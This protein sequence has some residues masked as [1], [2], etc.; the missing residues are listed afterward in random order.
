MPLELVCTLCMSN[1]GFRARLQNRVSEESNFKR[2][3]HSIFLLIKHEFLRLKFN[4]AA[5]R[6]ILIIQE[7]LRL[8]FKM[9]A[10]RPI[11]IIQYYRLLRNHLRM[12]PVKFQIIISKQVISIDVTRICWLT[13]SLLTNINHYKWM[14]D[15]IFN[16]S[17]LHVYYSFGFF[18]YLLKLP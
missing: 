15:H 5:K 8:K 7:F 10:K 2:L 11:L 17:N 3:S 14:A 16:N 13:A 4:M 1:R 12:F 6:P 18:K 9:A